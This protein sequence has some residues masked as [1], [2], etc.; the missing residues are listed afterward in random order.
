[1]HKSVLTFGLLMSS[2][3]MLAV[4]P[5]LNNNPAMAQGYY[6]DSYSIYPT[7]DKKYECRTGP[8]EGFFVS[9]VEFCKHAKFD[10]KKDRDAKVGPAGPQGPQGPAGPAGPQGQQGIQG[11][12]G[13]I[14]PNGT[15]GPSG[16]TQLNNT[17]TYS[18]TRPI[19]V[20]P[21]DDAIGE[22]F[23]ICDIGDF[24]ISGG[25]TLNNQSPKAVEFFTVT[26]SPFG[27]NAWKVRT[28]S[29]FAEVDVGGN[30][31]AKCFDNPPLR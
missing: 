1:M 4:M 29:N 3:V 5:F 27:E 18:I 9:S 13:P 22:G 12:Q 15:Q 8:F 21:G 31:T 30:V 24:A 19:V 7:D 6:D 20:S 25:Y 28:F 14:G 2:L 16:I 10:E 26:D 23:A 17:T 11:I